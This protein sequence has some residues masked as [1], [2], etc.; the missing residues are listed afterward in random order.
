MHKI[1]L[2]CFLLLVK[3]LNAQSPQKISYQGVARN[4]SG[5]V[6]S[7]TTIA[8][9]FDIHRSS[10]QGTIVFTEQHQGAAGLVTNTFGL[11]TT[12]IGS[13]SNLEGIDWSNGP[14]FMEV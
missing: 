11:F 2:V 6:L 8:V 14:F 13:I 7:N 9:K 10:P 12:A 4:A 3:L 5:A 1:V